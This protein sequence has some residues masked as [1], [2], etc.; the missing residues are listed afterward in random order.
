MQTKSIHEQK[1]LRK[2]SCHKINY[3]ASRLIICG[4]VLAFNKVSQLEL[5]L[6]HCDS[7]AHNFVY[8]VA[9]FY[10]LGRGCV[11]NEHPEELR[12]TGLKRRPVGLS[13]SVFVFKDPPVFVFDTFLG[14]VHHATTTTQ[15]TIS[16]LLFT[17]ITTKRSIFG[18]YFVKKLRYDSF[19]TYNLRNKILVFFTPCSRYFASGTDT[20]SC[21]RFG[22]TCFITFVLLAVFPL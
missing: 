18:Q 15:S 14:Q 19:L 9:S 10:R 7:Y 3:L 2:A 4:P 5:T 21:G 16:L 11:G 1:S 6:Q 8:N 13:S 20:M 17:K 22:E 12:P